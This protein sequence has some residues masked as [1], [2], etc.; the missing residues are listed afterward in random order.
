MRLVFGDILRTPMDPRV[1]C[2]AIKITVALPLVGRGAA[3]PRGRSRAPR[4]PH[5]PDATPHTPHDTQ[6]TRTHTPGTRAL[7]RRRPQ[8]D[9]STSLETREFRPSSKQKT[10]VGR[11]AVYHTS[12]ALERRGFTFRGVTHTLAYMRCLDSSDPSII[13]THSTLLYERAH[14]PYRQSIIIQYSKCNM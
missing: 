7:S 5:S 3:R 1:R 2:V 10:V 14:A 12:Q 6:D 11:L 9:R 13:R 8:V 4:T